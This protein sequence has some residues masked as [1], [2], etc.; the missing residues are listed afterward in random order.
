MGG[1]L[2]QQGRGD[3]RLRYRFHDLRQARAHVHDVRGRALFFLRDDKLRFLPETKVCLSLAFEAGDVTRLL[4]A[5]VAGRVEGAGAW[6]QLADV[7]PLRDLVP[8]E[9][10]RR[11]VRLGCDEQ[12]EA[13]A[14]QRSGSGRMLDVSPGGARL[15][16][17]TGFALGERIELRQLS[18][19]ALTFHDLSYAHVVWVDGEEMGVQFDRTDAVGRHAVARLLRQTEELWAKAWEGAH[20]SSCCGERGLLDPVPPREPERTA[21]HA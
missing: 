8:T 6:L 4:H 7:R 16:G 1:T 12:I 21:G 13:R 5:R 20:P 19:D 2:I 15:A 11:S 9:A 14:G 3:T 10:V 18:P 17:L